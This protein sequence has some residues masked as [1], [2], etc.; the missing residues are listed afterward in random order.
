MKLIIA[1]SRSGRLS[2]TDYARLDALH[3]ERPVTEVVSG[4]ASGIDKC[5]ETWAVRNRIPVKTFPADWEKYG[6]AAGPIRN[7]QMAEYADAVAL[8]PG[9][10]GTDS[11]FAEAQR[12]DLDIYDWR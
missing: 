12:F 4:F 1:G 6:K 3:A 5:G 10:K 9:G 2:E 7:R 8:F 11:M